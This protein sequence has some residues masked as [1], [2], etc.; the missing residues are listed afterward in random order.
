MHDKFFAVFLRDVWL[1][2][3]RKRVTEFAQKIG[4]VPTRASSQKRESGSSHLI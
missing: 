2:G 1:K 3:D 4:D